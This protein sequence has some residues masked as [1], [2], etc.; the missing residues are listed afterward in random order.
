[1]RPKITCYSLH[2]VLSKNWDDSERIGLDHQVARRFLDRKCWSFLRARESA[3]PQ[4]QDFIQARLQDPMPTWHEKPRNL[5]ILRASEY[6]HSTP[7]FSSA[8]LPLRSGKGKVSEHDSF[9]LSG[10]I[11]P[12]FKTCST[13]N[14]VCPKPAGRHRHGRWRPAC[15]RF[16]L[17][18]LRWLS[19]TS[20]AR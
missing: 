17:P 3:V 5:N 18:C 1:M 9:G 8:A 16:S 20:R 10:V 2:P 11:F 4:K 15:L 7:C 12:S 6:L 19:P 13:L 14:S